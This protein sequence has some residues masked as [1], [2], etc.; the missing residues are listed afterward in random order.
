MRT[1]AALGRLGCL[2]LVRY[3]GEWGAGLEELAGEAREFDAVVAAGGDG[4][5]NAVG[6]GLAAA[7]PRVPLAVL[8]LG[9]VNLV[10]REIRIPRD[11]ERLA[12]AIASGP[13]RPAWPGRI[14]ER[15]FMTVAGCGFD[16]GI[17]AAV[18]P[19]LK[20]RIG[21]LAFIPPIL[22]ASVVRPGPPLSLTIDGDRTTAA[23]VIVAKGRYYAGPF[24]I[25][26]AAE[27]TEPVLYAVLFRSSGRGAI[28]AALAGIAS[29]MLPRLPA[30]EIRRCTTIEVTGGDTVAVQADGEI[31]GSLPTTISVASRP[32][33]LIWPVNVA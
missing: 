13:V 1:V 14:G 6:N 32:I 5:V 22:R 19:A 28:A 12:A 26:P 9:T 21:R 11:P 31:I 27:I 30:V 24:R 16:A 20:S 7:A 23:A 15:L 18:D 29:G 33:D 17:V 8:P 10:A 2:V 4:T 25:A 3:S